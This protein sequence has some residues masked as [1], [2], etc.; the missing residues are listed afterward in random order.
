MAQHTHVSH[1]PP[2]LTY[3]HG[4]LALQALW[5]VGPGWQGSLLLQQAVPPVAGGWW[6][7]HPSPLT[8]GH[9]SLSRLSC[10]GSLS[11]Y[12]QRDGGGGGGKQRYGL[13]MPGFR[14]VYPI[15]LEGPQTSVSGTGE[16]EEEGTQPQTQI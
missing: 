2:P 12:Q 7:L 1:C 9:V 3:L 5:W 14:H 15:D 8:Q 16:G 4:V 13:I 10:G 6:G 11:L